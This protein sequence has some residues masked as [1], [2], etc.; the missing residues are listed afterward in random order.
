M[1]YNI[2]KTIKGKVVVNGEAE[3][4]TWREGP[5]APK[6]TSLIF[7]RALWITLLGLVGGVLMGAAVFD[8]DKGFILSILGFALLLLAIIIGAFGLRSL[9]GG[10][11]YWH[12]RLEAKP[13]AFSIL[14]MFAVAVGGIVELVPGL[15][16][17]KEVPLLADGG[18]AV[19]PYTPLE[20]EGRDIYVREGC[21]VCHSQMIRPF[22]SEF[23]RYGPPSTMAESMFD[24]PFQWGS[25]RTGPDL[26]REGT[27]GKNITWHFNHMLDP[28]STSPGSIMPP[29][30]WLLEAKVPY[31]R[32]VEKL[33]AQRTLGVPFSDKDIENCEEMYKTQASAIVRYLKKNQVGT[34]AMDSELVALIAYLRRLGHGRRKPLEK[35]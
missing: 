23:L 27:N 28:R 2:A 4:V 5:D 12:K 20:L 8:R 30:P 26:A 31:Q 1:I 19:E 22:R 17:Q 29:Y 9:R 6:T 24:H 15:I 33:K 34:A 14:A 35:E 25:K 32:T 18:P 16:A 10:Q 11:G 21:Y 3:V 7:S 13:L